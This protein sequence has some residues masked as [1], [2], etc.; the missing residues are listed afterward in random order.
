MTA[1]PLPFY[2]LKIK[3]IFM[4]DTVLRTIRKRGEELSSYNRSRQRPESDAPSSVL[5][6]AQ[7]SARRTTGVEKDTAR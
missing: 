6:Q 3:L 5:Y 1:R 4:E 2:S 7:L